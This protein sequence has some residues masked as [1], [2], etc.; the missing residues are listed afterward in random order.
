MRSTFPF[1]VNGSFWLGSRLDSVW[2]LRGRVT[3][4]H[5]GYLET[6]L[7][8]GIIGL[9]LFVVFLLASYRNICR[10]ELASKESFASLALAMWAV[11]VFYMV[12]EAG[13]RGGLL[14]VVF[15]LLVIPV[16]VGADSATAPYEV[17]EHGHTFDFG[18]IPITDDNT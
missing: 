14:S 8:L 17:T 12:T 6:Y 10:K 16:P 9:F 5:N 3:E 15:L 18:A 11:M 13:F 2:E 4:A 7:N 1:G